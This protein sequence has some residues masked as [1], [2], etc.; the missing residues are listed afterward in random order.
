MSAYL[1]QAH[2]LNTAKI[3]IFHPVAA[4]YVILKI[5]KFNTI[6]SACLPASQPAIGPGST[7]AMTPDFHT[8][9]VIVYIY[10]W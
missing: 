7:H 5:S 4:I 2:L 6:L 10:S 8:I 3:Q 1:M 9:K